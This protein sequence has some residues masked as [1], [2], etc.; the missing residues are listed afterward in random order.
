MTSLHKSWA[1]S[2][3][4]TFCACQ[5]SS[6]PVKKAP[7]EPIY[8]D[9]GW[10]TETR[11]EFRATGQG[12]LILP[13]DWFRVLEQADST[14]PF[15]SGKNLERFR[16]IPANPS[17]SNPDGMPVGFVKSF[18]T[19]TNSQ[20]IGLNCAGCHT[21]QI[22][23]EATSIL[24]DGAPTMGDFQT[25]IGELEAALKSTE[26]DP[27]KFERFAKNVLGEAFSDES[28]EDLRASFSEVTR[29]EDDLQETVEPVSHLGVGENGYPGNGLRNSLSLVIASPHP[30]FF[31]NSRASASRTPSRP[32]ISG[33]SAT[34]DA[35]SN[36]PNAPSW[37]SRP[38]PAA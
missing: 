31:D 35:S 10:S 17:G 12:S 29:M 25:F 4:V 2:F 1:L 38:S 33:G 36:T 20:W 18:N 13:Y 28:S 6:G 27:E 9:Q 26:Q 8:L 21:A 7:V 5:P 32:N 15:R 23:Y 34:S 22:D 24:V 14:D 19:D 30:V 16:Y 3:A 11:N 37:A